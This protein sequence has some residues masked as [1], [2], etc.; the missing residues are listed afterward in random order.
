M[1]AISSCRSTLVVT[2]GAGIPR[3]GVHAQSPDR[4]GGYYTSAQGLM[5]GDSYITADEGIN[6]PPGTRVEEQLETKRFPARFP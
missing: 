5:M 2:K 4:Q 6:A 3:A 1:G